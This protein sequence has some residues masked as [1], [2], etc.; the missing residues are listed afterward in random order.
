MKRIIILIVLLATPVFSQYKGFLNELADE[1]PNFLKELHEEQMREEA[2][3]YQRQQ[4]LINAE[5]LRLERERFEYDKGVEK[6]KEIEAFQKAGF[7]LF[8]TNSDG[9]YDLYALDN[10]GDTEF[11]I[12]VIDSNFDG[13][14]DVVEFD[15]NG[16][17]VKDRV[18]NDNDNNGTLEYWLFDNDGDGKWD[19]A[20]VD[21]DGD[22]FPDVRFPYVVKQ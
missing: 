8:D 2:L 18:L 5:R 7:K 15:D 14:I 3:E 16:D 4:T 10:I 21:T 6:R 1:L 12:L 19:E 13:S 9:E 22:Y 20:G 17:G 11:D